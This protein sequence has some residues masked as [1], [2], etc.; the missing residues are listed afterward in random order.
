MQGN[1]ETVRLLRIKALGQ[2]DQIA[3]FRPIEL[4]GEANIQRRSKLVHRPLGSKP[5]C[6]AEQGYDAYASNSQAE[7]PNLVALFQRDHGFRSLITEV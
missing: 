7:L 6:H 4:G 5:C 1:H 3:L 2:A